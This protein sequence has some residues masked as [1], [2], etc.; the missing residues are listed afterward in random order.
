LDGSKGAVPPRT[1]QERGDVFVQGTALCLCDAFALRRNGA[2]ARGRGEGA[3]S[4]GLVASAVQCGAGKPGASPLQVLDGLRLRKQIRG[5]P[6]ASE[7][8]AFARIAFGFEICG[9]EL[10]RRHVIIK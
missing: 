3:V 5:R 10:A 7:K 6:P 4:G 9:E 1:P 8:R 2:P